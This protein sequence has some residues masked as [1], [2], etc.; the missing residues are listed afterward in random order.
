MT[1]VPECAGLVALM[2]SQLAKAIVTERTYRREGVK[3]GITRSNRTLRHE[4][5]SV[6]PAVIRLEETM[7]MLESWIDKEFQ[8]MLR[9]KTHDTGTEQHGLIRE[10][11]DNVEIELVALRCNSEIGRCI[12]KIKGSYLVS[13]DE[14]T[15]RLP[16][17]KDTSGWHSSTHE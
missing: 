3:E 15:R 9:Q 10:L 5:D 12:K 16:I 4:S 1:M 11:V 13:Y 14:G 17:N 2:Q 7:P 6:R 8:K